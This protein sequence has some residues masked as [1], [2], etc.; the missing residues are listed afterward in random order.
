MAHDGP[1]PNRALLRFEY[2][3]ERRARIVERSVGVEVG[4][5]DD[6]R[7]AATVE[8]D[9]RSVAVRVSAADLVALRAGVNS[10]TRMVSVAER[11]IDAAE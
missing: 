3:D 10:W 8:R 2:D 6:A 4:E 7:S 11:T 5:I 1:R 9:G